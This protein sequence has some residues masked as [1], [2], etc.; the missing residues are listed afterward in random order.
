[1]KKSFTIARLKTA[2]IKLK[3]LRE[4]LKD[5]FEGIDIQNKNCFDKEIVI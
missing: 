4:P 5:L 3:L 1:M 2:K